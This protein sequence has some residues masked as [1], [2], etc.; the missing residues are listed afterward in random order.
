MTLHFCSVFA[1]LKMS[2][3]MPVGWDVTVDKNDTMISTPSTTPSSTPLVMPK[4]CSWTLKHTEGIEGHEG[5][6]SLCFEDNITNP[7]SDDFSSQTTKLKTRRFVLS[8]ITQTTHSIPV[9]SWKFLPNNLGLHS[10]VFY[11]SVGDTN[12]AIYCGNKIKNTKANPSSKTWDILNGSDLPP[13]IQVSSDMFLAIEIEKANTKLIEAKNAIKTFLL[14]AYDENH[15]WLKTVGFVD[16]MTSRL[17][18]L[19]SDV[20]NTEN[21]L[22]VST[23]YSELN[24]KIFR[25]S[26]VEE[27]KFLDSNDVEGSN[28]YTGKG[29]SLVLKDNSEEQDSECF[30][31]HPEFETPIFTTSPP[32][33]P[34]RAN[35]SNPFL[36]KP[37]SLGEPYLKNG[38]LHTTL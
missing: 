34:P 15:N 5:H 32:L 22:E 20:L 8:K 25:L 21:I 24:G 36:S 12:F 1:Y 18:K 11:G 2:S 13:D 28:P 10:I 29:A 35:R 17:S 9:D 33:K 38:E 3:V 4:T 37:P 23:K 7:W 14:K 31:D 6:V 26:P 19:N 30:R 27:W 16:Y